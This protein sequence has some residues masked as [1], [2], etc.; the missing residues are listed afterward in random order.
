MTLCGEV[1]L[2]PP[3]SFCQTWGNKIYNDRPFL[4]GFDNDTGL[5][6][7]LLFKSMDWMGFIKIVEVPYRESWLPRQWF[8]SQRALLFLR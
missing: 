1:P 8:S 5:S 6:R 4:Y 2:S 7:G 3:W